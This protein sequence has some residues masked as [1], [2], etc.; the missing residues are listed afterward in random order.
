MGSPCAPLHQWPARAESAA[1]SA[2]CLSSF[3][4]VP[5]SCSV[6]ETHETNHAHASR[7]ASPSSWI[8]E[9]SFVRALLRLSLPMMAQALLQDVFSIVDMLFVGRLGPEAVAAVGACGTL[10]GI[11]FM[12][13]VGITTGCMALVAQAVGAGNR[14]RAGSVVGQGLFMALVISI[15]VG[16]LGIPFANNMLYVLG[17]QPGVVAAGTPYL[18][19]SSAGALAMMLS[20]TFASSLRGAGDAVTPLKVFGLANVLNIIL[21]PI[22]IFGWLGMPALGVSGSALATVI[23][24]LFAAALL[25]RVFFG[26]AH[27]QFHLHWADLA[28]RPAILWHMLKIGVFSSAQVLIRNI[29][30]IFLVRI[31]AVFGT[32][33]LAAYA[34]GIRLRMMLMMPGMGFGNAAATLVGQNLGAAKPERAS[35]A[36]WL[37][38]GVYALVAIPAA[39]VLIAFAAPIVSIFNDTPE[40]VAN[41]AK[42]LR[43]FSASVA[44]MC[45]SMVLGRAMNGA[46]DTFWPM[47]ITA[48][49]MI[50]FRIPLSY[51]LARA[52][53]DVTGVW[54]ALAASNVAQGALFAGVFAW[55]RWKAIGRRLVESANR[56][57]D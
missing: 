26:G 24:R 31:V 41:G 13:S 8:T 43:W 52:M 10:M 2:A 51:G 39:L 27:Q 33:A 34:I 21:D 4:S 11:F 30:A 18:R 25:A 54:I 44:F 55:G 37:T 48:A 47:L 50:A 38:V 22:L 3:V 19:I 53:Q 28:P 36:A 14:A 23:A 29:S 17:L 15:L 40:V 12:L 49:G 9:G 1:A 20:V 35:K 57:P 32:A 56:H 42:F 7:R 16:A 46:G 45:L 6:T 5:K